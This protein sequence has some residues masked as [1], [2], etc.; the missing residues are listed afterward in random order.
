LAFTLNANIKRTTSGTLSFFHANI[1]TSLV[2]LFTSPNKDTA[3]NLAIT[4][5]LA[6]PTK[7]S[8]R[9]PHM[10]LSSIL[11]CNRPLWQSALIQP[12]PNAYLMNAPFSKAS[13]T[14]S[15]FSPDLLSSQQ[16]NAGSSPSIPSPDS[17]PFLTRNSSIA[18]DETTLC[19]SI[20]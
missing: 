5:Y 16:S 14:S 12:C 6:H 15:N 4:S 9:L 13:F 8:Q 11:F 18:D 2:N 3:P 19:P 7:A 17:H 10:L 20:P 1:I